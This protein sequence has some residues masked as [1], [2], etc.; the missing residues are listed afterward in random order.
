MSDPTTKGMYLRCALQLIADSEGE[1]KM[2]A[3]AA[4]LGVDP[5]PSELRSYPLSDLTRMVFTARDRFWPDESD[6]DL[7]ERFGANAFGTFARSLVGRVGLNLTLNGDPQHVAESVVG[8]QKATTKYGLCD[9]ASVDDHS[10]TL[11]YA[12]A[13]DPHY[14]LGLMKVG[15]ELGGGGKVELANVR[16]CVRDDDHV[17][18]ADFDLKVT[19]SGG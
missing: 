18:D 8:M 1:D 5:E 9:I 10:F 2:R 15:F 14:T 19:L 12:G 7:A 16:R 3:L 17:A 11:R 13:I 6:A 4:E